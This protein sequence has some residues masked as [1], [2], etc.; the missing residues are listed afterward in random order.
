MSALL[1]QPPIP[2]N[3]S[4]LSLDACPRKGW[5]PPSHLQAA[6]GIAGR[7]IYTL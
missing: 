3:R 2:N 6:L 1:Y 4:Y 5:G 7:V